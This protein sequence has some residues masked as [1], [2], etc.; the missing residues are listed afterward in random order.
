ML[1][2]VKTSGSPLN[3]ILRYTE[4]KKLVRFPLFKRCCPEWWNLNE[5]HFYCFI[6]RYRYEL[7]NDSIVQILWYTGRLG[8]EPLS[9]W[10]CK[11]MAVNHLTIRKDWKNYTSRLFDSIHFVGIHR[12]RVGF[13]T[14]ILS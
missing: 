14:E 11:G 10:D 8:T 5:W 2:V 9:M 3:G 6:R 13:N 1:N 12:K 7:F 4:K